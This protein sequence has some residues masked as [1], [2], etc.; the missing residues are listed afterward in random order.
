MQHRHYAY[1][2]ALIMITLSLGACS[3]FDLGD[4]VRVKTPNRV[5]QSTGLAATTSLNEAERPS[6]GHGS[7][8]RNARARSGSPTSNGPVKS[9]A[10]LANSL[11]PHSINSA[12]PWR[13]FP[14]SAQHCPR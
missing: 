4:I 11:S 13:A 7:R 9:E 3:G 6:I 8:K 1:I 10:S 2:F 5:Q 14:C 12:Q